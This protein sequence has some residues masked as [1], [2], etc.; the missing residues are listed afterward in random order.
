MSKAMDSR[1]H[2]NHHSDK[3]SPPRVRN[4]LSMFGKIKQ[5]IADANSPYDRFREQVSAE[6][7]RLEKDY[8]AAA[9]VHAW[10]EL[11]DA[12]ANGRN[13]RVMEAALEELGRRR[14]D[15]RPGRPRVVKFRRGL[16]EIA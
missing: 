16:G 4:V 10:F 1:A 3:A 9:Y 15:A 13:A 2:Q 5:Y 12:D 6:V 14:A 7:T 8:A 11:A